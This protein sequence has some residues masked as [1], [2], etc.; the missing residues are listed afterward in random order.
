MKYILFGLLFLLMACSDSNTPKSTVDIG[1]YSY[2]T[3]DYYISGMH[4]K[5]FTL[6]GNAIYIVNI[7]KDSLEVLK[8]TK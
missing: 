6:Y 4:Y 5:A 7:T 8:L 3:T 1:L 2:T